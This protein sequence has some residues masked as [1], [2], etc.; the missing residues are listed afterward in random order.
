MYLIVTAS[1]DTYITNKILD[2]SYRA[3]DANVGRAGTIDLFKLWNESEISGST[4]PTE[5]SRALIKFDLDRIYALTQS[6]IDLNHSTFEA[7]IKM[8]DILGGQATPAN[9]NLLIYPLSRSFDEG[10]GRDV[11]T[12]GDLDACNFITSSYSSATANLWFMSGASSSGILGSDDIDYITSGTLDGSFVDFGKSQNF[13]KGNEDLEIDV[14][15]IL[16]ATLAGQ[17]PNHGFRI[18][19]SGSEETDNKTRFV[20]RFASRHSSNPFKVP[21]LIVTCDDTIIDHHADFLF[22]IS[23]SLFLNNYHRGIPSNILSGASATAITGDNSVMLKLQKGDWT[24]YITGS[25]HAIGTANA[26]DAGVYSASFAIPLNDSQAINK[27]KEKLIDVIHKSGSVIFD[28]YWTSVDG[29]VG[30]HTGSLEVKP[31]QRSSY[32]SQPSSLEFRFMNL[33]QEYNQTDVVTLKI[34]VNDLNETSK[35]YKTPFSK[36]SLALSN[37]YYRIREADNGTIVIPFK[38]TNSATKLSSDSDGM[39]FEFRMQNLP[40]GHSYVIDLLVKDFGLN[41]T[42]E[43]VSTRFRIIS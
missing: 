34:F 28:E 12:F 11:S 19:Y 21:Q 42:Y 29:S 3:R 24:K 16:S 4:R 6:A 38:S 25:Q 9:F 8:F 41:K 39:Y 43:A 40:A 15:T 30:Y 10:I 26:N 35:F 23:G 7:K 22:D 13:I 17:I 5:I 31:P 27:K 18:A 1:K 36:K 2:N 14:T 37:V 32:V 20:K 33:S